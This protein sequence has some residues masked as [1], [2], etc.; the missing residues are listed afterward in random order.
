[1]SLSSQGR[2]RLPS[3]FSQLERCSVK[4]TIFFPGVEQWRYELVQAIRYGHHRLHGLAQ[5]LK[6][7][8]FLAAG[9]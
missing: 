6:S 5:G 8:F 1:V 7:H 3:D 2:A 4:N 9:V